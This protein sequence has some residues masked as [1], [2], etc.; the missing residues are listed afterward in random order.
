MTGVQTCALPI[1][2]TPNSEQGLNIARNSSISRVFFHHSLVWR[3]WERWRFQTEACLGLY[4][5]VDKESMGQQRKTSTLFSTCS[6]T[7]SDVRLEDHLYWAKMKYDLYDVTWENKFSDSCPIQA[8]DLDINSD[9]RV[10]RGWMD[11]EESF[12]PGLRSPAHQLW[13]QTNND[14][15]IEET[16]QHGRI[17]ESVLDKQCFILL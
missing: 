15:F 4:A 10:G 9:V 13:Q 5:L 11:R 12:T 1:W 8:I 14:W 3:G 16:Y 2:T 7:F 6:L 17:I